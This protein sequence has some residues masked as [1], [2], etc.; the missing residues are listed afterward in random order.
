MKTPPF[1][2]IFPSLFPIVHLDSPIKTSIFAGFSHVS[3]GF[4][5]AHS[6]WRIQHPAFWRA[7]FEPEIL[8]NRGKTEKSDMAKDD[9]I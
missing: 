7:F 3:H 5:H 8:E 2:V 9:L 1:I 4:S 6:R